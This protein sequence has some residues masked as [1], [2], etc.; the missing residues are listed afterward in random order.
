M[1]LVL[2]AKPPAG[3]TVLSLRRGRLRAHES[4]PHRVGP[5]DCARHRRGLCWPRTFLQIGF[6]G[7]P[8]P[9]ARKKDTRLRAAN[10]APPEVRYFLQDRGTPGGGRPPPAPE[11][12]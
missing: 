8:P 2:P 5:G 12:L 4:K 3:D 9:W 11:N 6:F 10:P 7:A 1:R